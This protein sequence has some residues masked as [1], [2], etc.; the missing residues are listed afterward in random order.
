M[1]FNSTGDTDGQNLPHDEP[2]SVPKRRCP[3][4]GELTGSLP[5]H[6]PVCVS[7]DDG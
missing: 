2:Y 3:N 5:N 6:V 1:S 7:E 4:C